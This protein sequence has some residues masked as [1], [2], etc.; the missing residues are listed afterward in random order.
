MHGEKL[1]Y[2]AAVCWT[3]RARYPA[4]HLLKDPVNNSCKRHILLQWS[5]TAC[6]HL[7]SGT[8]KALERADGDNLS[9]FSV[10]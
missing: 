10:S 3:M 1:S 7:G 6:T 4:W 5:P 9:S 2:A 8:E